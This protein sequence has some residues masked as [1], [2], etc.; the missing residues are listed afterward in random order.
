MPDRYCVPTSFPVVR[1][2]EDFQQLVIADA[3][4][5]ID[6]EHRLVVPGKPRA[7]FLVGRVRRKHPC[8]TDRGHMHAR[9]LPE[10]PLRASEAAEPE[11]RLLRA[12]GVWAFKSGAV[13]EM[14]L[15]GG[16][17]CAAARES[18]IRGGHWE[19]LAFQREQGSRRLM[20]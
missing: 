20:E 7:N 17:W 12:L 5:V 4:G 19:G 11:Q 16:N 18:L 1:L 9:D 14:S 15:C 6:N 10:I 13:H 3:L 2:P 8:I